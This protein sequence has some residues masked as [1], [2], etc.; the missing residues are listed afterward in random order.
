[1][2]DTSVDRHSALA[3]DTDWLTALGVSLLLM[4]CLFLSGLSIIDYMK[5]SV[6]TAA[7][8]KTW[9]VVAALLFAICRL[10]DRRVQFALAL[11]AVNPIC[12]IV[13]KLGKVSSITENTAIQF[14]RI[15][16]SSA[17]LGLAL[18]MGAWFLGKVRR[19]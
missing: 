5:N 16:Q 10:T 13:L 3:L 1:M 7:S 6:P 11:V 9:F 18:Y 4:A 15:L 8:W 19:A 14:A 2:R 12:R 17:F